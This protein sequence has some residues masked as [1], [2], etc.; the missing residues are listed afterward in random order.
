MRAEQRLARQALRAVRRG[1]PSPR[2]APQFDALYSERYYDYFR[3]T[4]QN[5][6]AA[7][8]RY[9]DASRHDEHIMLHREAI[10][11]NYGQLI[12][13]FLRTY[14]RD[15]N[16]NMDRTTLNDWRGRAAELT[17]GAL[18]ARLRHPNILLVPSLAF[19]DLSANWEKNHDYLYIDTYADE[20]LVQPVQVKAT[21]GT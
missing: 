8:L 19:Q 15:Q 20:P 13:T 18:I 14:D 5:E 3:K 4:S 21:A 1:E 16:H 17:I 11:G 6:V 10:Y 9:F 2:L 12:E 7:F